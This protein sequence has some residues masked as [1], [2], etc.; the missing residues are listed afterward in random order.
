M[1]RCFVYGTLLSGEPN[2]RVLRGS[3]CLGPARTPPRFKL[4]DLGAYPGMLA[5]GNTSVVG[6]LYEVNDDVLAA[7]DRLEGHPRYYLRAPIVLAGWQRAETYFFPAAHAAE[8]AVIE[9]G[10]WRLWNKAKKEKQCAW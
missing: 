5:D 1:T 10:D 8:R 6:E 4:I 9:S 2:H 3:R 7:L